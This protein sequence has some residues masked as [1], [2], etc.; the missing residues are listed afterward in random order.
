VRFGLKSSTR[1]T[2]GYFWVARLFAGDLGNFPKR[3]R[4]VPRS[5][6]SSQVPKK[7]V[8]DRWGRGLFAHNRARLFHLFICSFLLLF[9]QSNP[10]LTTFRRKK[11]TEKMSA[12]TIGMMEG[13]FFVGRKEIMDWVNSTLDLNLSKVEETASGEHTSIETTVILSVC[14]LLPAPPYSSACY[15]CPLPFSPLL[16]CS[17]ACYVCPLPFSPLLFCSLPPPHPQAPAPASC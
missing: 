13:A 9:R 2:V 17:S 3:F 1:P 10:T 11:K 5:L 16:F 7:M 4:K 14:C 15:V 8:E 6:K 12:S